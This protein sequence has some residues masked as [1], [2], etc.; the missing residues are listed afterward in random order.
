MGSGIQVWRRIITAADHHP[1]GPQAP[2]V[3]VPPSEE[4]L[5][6]RDFEVVDGDDALRCGRQ[7]CEGRSPKW[8]GQLGAMIP[9]HWPSEFEEPV[10]RSLSG[11]RVEEQFGSGSAETNRLRRS[12]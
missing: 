9:A 7:P 1:L 6:G 12:M 10:N 3:P 4:L 2:E 11:N 5:P 8:Q